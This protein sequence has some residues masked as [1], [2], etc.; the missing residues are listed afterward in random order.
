MMIEMQQQRAEGDSY[1]LGVATAIN[2]L[3]I[4]LPICQQIY[5]H[6][7][8]YYSYVLDFIS[9]IR[10]GVSRPSLN[11]TQT[12]KMYRYQVTL[13]EIHCFAEKWNFQ[14]NHFFLH[15]DDIVAS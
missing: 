14:L 13:I 2:C 11:P 4:V 10:G 15:N 3:G 1:H 12:D 9:S 7:H 8:S 6:V 5:R